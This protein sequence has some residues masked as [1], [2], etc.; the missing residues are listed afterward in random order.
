MARR[1]DFFG[2]A[3]NARIRMV[4]STT[5]VSKTF[6]DIPATMSEDVRDEL[7]SRYA[8]IVMDKA[9]QNITEGYQISK[10]PVSEDTQRKPIGQLGQSIRSHQEGDRLDIFFGEGLPYGDMHNV[11]IGEHTLIAG[12]RMVFPNRRVAAKAKNR[13]RVTNAVRRP[14]RGF[15]SR[16]VE[17]TR[18]ELP[19]LLKKSVDM[20]RDSARGTPFQTTSSGGKVWALGSMSADTAMKRGLIGSTMSSSGRR[21]YYLTAAGREYVTKRNSKGTKRRKVK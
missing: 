16:A 10:Y 3:R 6:M 9:R 17:D 1:K 11:P 12:K 4:G 7:F 13:I 14:G 5:R 21:D 18:R 15:M 8:V 20:Y 2:K 19:K